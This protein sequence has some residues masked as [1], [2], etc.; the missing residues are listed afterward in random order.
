MQRDKSHT[1][2]LTFIGPGLP[3]I[4]ARLVEKSSQLGL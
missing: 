3:S 1:A 4:P 2:A